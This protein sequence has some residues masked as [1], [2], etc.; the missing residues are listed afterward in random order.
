MATPRKGNTASKAV[1]INITPDRIRKLKAELIA[2]GKTEL[3]IWDESQKGLGVRARTGREPAFI[4]AFRQDGNFRK[5]TLGVCS[6][7]TIEDARELAGEKYKQVKSGED[8]E[9]VMQM[10]TKER[11]DLKAQEEKDSLTLLDGWKQYVE[12]HEKGW[13]KSHLRDHHAMMRE[14]G[15]PTRGTRS[16]QTIAGPLWSLA[17]ERLIDVPARLE[18]W[19]KKE[20]ATRPTS[21]RKAF[22]LMKT[23]MA[24]HGVELSESIDNKTQRR[25]KRALPKPQTKD[26]VLDASQLSAWWSEVDKLPFVSRAY[27]MSLLLLGCRREELAQLRWADVDLKWNRLTLNDKV[28]ENRVIPLP[29]PVKALMLDLKHRGEVVDLEREGDRLK[30]ARVTGSVEDAGVGD[31]ELVFRGIR[32]HG[33]PSIVH[34]H[35]TRAA[36]AAGLPHITQHGLRRTF[37][38]LGEEAGI[39][40]GAVAQICGHKPS[41]LIERSYKR[42]SLD[43]LTEYHEQL[44]GWILTQAVVVKLLALV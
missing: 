16:K 25:I 28:E 31:L 14:P 23:C 26:D 20:S 21:A 43:K 7:L 1:R 17:H 27:L 34:K 35:H 6:G 19:L 39:P 44:A 29:S 40:S 12:E 30:R 24:W 4:Y 2:S 41:A 3:V 32:G 18:A 9:H 42:R 38:T 15:Q 10:K 11:A 22:V 5:I 13:S 33:G 8:P 37:I 36:E